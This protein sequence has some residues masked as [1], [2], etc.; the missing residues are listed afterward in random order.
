MK[1]LSINLLNLLPFLIKDMGNYK[2][3]KWA[4]KFISL[5]NTDGIWG[6]MFHSIYSPNTRYPLTTKGI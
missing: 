1:F 2:N 5:Q 4:E 6:D 3:G